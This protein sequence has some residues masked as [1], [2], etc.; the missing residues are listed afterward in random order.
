MANPLTS[1]A[2]AIGITL[3]IEPVLKPEARESPRD[4]SLQ[5]A[6]TTTKGQEHYQVH[7]SS[8]INNSSELVNK[9]MATIKAI[10]G[11]DHRFIVA[12]HPQANGAAEAHI[13]L[14]KSVLIK[15]VS[16]DWS[17]W[18]TFL[19]AAQFVINQKLTSRHKSTP[20]ELFLGCPVNLLSDFSNM[21]S[22]PFLRLTTLHKLPSDTIILHHSVTTSKMDPKYL[23]SFFVKCRTKSSVYRLVDITGNE[24]KDHIPPSLLKLT[25]LE[26]QVNPDAF[27]DVNS[28]SNDDNNDD[29]SKSYKVSKVLTTM[30]LP[31]AENTRSDRKATLLSMT[32]GFQSRTSMIFNLLTPTGRSFVQ[33]GGNVGKL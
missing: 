4:F 9:T 10:S 2:D 6:Q 19:P 25:D 5:A 30:D 28:E 32:S 3:E 27:N 23:S 8:S 31:T 29:Y 24:L 26:S 11:F 17:H 15:L 1:L 22:N 7:P 12:Y 21:E 14:A 33:K 18:S 13:K 16:S 20:F